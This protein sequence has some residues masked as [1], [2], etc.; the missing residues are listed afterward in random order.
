MSVEAPGTATDVQLKSVLMATDFSPASDKALPHAVAIA[1][2]YG[3][4]IYLAHIVSSLRFAK[5]GPEAIAC[6]KTLALRDAALVERK[7]VAIGALNGLHH[8]VIVRDGDIWNELHMIIRHAH[9]DLVVTGTHGRTGLK[10]LVLGLVAEQ[11]FRHAACLVLSVG[12]HSSTDVDLGEPVRVGPLVFATDFSDASLAAL[13]YA[14]SFAKQRSTRLVL[15]HMLAP[16]PHVDGDR[17]YT[18]SDVTQMEKESQ[19]Q[20]LD[21]LNQL[22]LDG[23][24]E[25]QPLRIAE[26]GEP[27]EGILS[28]AKKLRAEVIVL[29]L[30]R[31]THIETVSH[32]PWSTAYKVVCSAACPVLTV[33]TEGALR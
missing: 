27:S 30:H 12:P 9:I 14:I 23:K 28:I 19:E 26:Y 10:K 16:A 22:T 2:H 25:L 18:A 32:L 5:A 1:R 3:A 24:L 29:G 21:R 13:P 7:L 20:A 15:L 31:K 8:E 11:I 4:K 33:G 17:W 6:S